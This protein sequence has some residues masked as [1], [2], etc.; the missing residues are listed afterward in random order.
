MDDIYYE[1]ILNR[2]IQ[3]R[4][5]VKLGDLVLFISE[6][7][8]DVLEE[9][10]DIWQEYYDLSYYSGDVYSKDEILE[11][12]LEN[13]MWDPHDDQNADQ[14]EEQIEELKVQ[15]FQAH[16]NVKKL[17][18]IKRQIR[19]VEKLMVD[20]RMKSKQLD[21]VT[22]SGLA[23]FARKSWLVSRTTKLADGSLFDFGTHSLSTIMD[24][25]AH[26]A[27]EPDTFRRIAR[28][29][30]WRAMWGSGKAS[31]MVFGK[32][33]CDLD[34]N[35]LSLCSFSS[36]Y[37]NVFESPDAPK[38]SIIED[39][40]CLD[41][42]FIVQK[43]KYEQQKKEMEKNQAVSNSKI[44][45]SDEVFLMADDQYEA[46]EIYAMNDPLAR[47]T[48]KQR[49]AQIKNADGE[50]IHLRDLKDVKED[51]YMAR[52]EAQKQKMGQMSKGGR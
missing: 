1:K 26:H 12:L 14:M 33:S 2:I 49:Q 29:N 15:A 38:E 37:D 34:T 46:Q 18:G 8:R 13:D 10:Y 21:H 24:L 48:I 52:V 35:Q 47:Q 25:Y 36:M 23:N 45:S 17:V 3:G 41:G 31:G 32:P 9:S 39:N 43:R 6:P 27:I 40:D 16:F 50:L 7:S 30:P 19:H 28:T 4:L 11:I 22:C 20:L 42:W 44:A 51:N 5:R